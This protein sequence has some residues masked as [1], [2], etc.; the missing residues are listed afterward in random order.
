MTLRLVVEPAAEN[1]LLEA[2]IWYEDRQSG[3]GVAFINE[4]EVC[5][6]LIVERPEIYQEIDRNIHRAVTR[7]FPYC[8]FYTTSA[9]AISVLAVLHAAQHPEYLKSRINA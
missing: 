3:L 1:D 4:V 9:S 5:F 6:D 8:V 7:T 2:F